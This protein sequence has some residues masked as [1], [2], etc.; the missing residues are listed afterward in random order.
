MKFTIDRNVY[1]GALDKVKK[2]LKDDDDTL[3]YIYH[4]VTDKY[5]R[6]VASDSDVQIEYLVPVG[7]SLTVEEEGKSCPLGQKLSDL[8]KGFPNVS[9]TVHNESE[10]IE[11][12]EEDSP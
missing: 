6:L 3:K 7:E 11:D 12:T 10:I 8:I 2:A 4:E 5:L 9:V 1:S